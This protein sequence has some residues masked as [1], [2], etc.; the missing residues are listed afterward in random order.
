MQ[1]PRIQNSR[2]SVEIAKSV[3]GIATGRC[4]LRLQFFF[5]VYKSATTGT[6]RCCQCAKQSEFDGMFATT[7]HVLLSRFQAKGM[8]IGVAD[9]SL[10]GIPYEESS[11]SE[12]EEELEE[13]EGEERSTISLKS[14]FRVADVSCVPFA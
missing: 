12:E 8:D 9:E 7:L 3:V 4:P 6:R 13:T 10:N 2:A 14:G 11:E 1:S 5:P